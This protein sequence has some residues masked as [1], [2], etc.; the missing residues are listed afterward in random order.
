MG[1][2]TDV[3][4][5]CDFNEVKTIKANGDKKI[6]SKAS[7]IKVTK[8]VFPVLMSSLFRFLLFISLSSQ[9]G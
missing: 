6:N 8:P 9:M 1:E 2:P 5:L 3:I 4:W 7:V